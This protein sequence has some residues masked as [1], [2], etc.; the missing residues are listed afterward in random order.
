M[1]KKIILLF[2]T[3][4]FTLTFF[5]QKLVPDLTLKNL[6]GKKV[7][8]REVSKDK[9]IVF[10]FWD[11]ACKPC[12][13]ELNAIHEQYEDLQEEFGFELI[14]VSIDGSKTISKVK[15]AVN[16]YEWDYQVLLDTKKDFFKALNIPPPP[17]VIIVKDNVLRYGKSGYTTGSEEELFEKFKAIK[18]K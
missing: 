10:S 5:S 17:V 7:S 1:I 18:K 11:T 4:L 2:A 13:A 8:L 14:A 12:I 15:P 6:D 3:L 16:G 9:T